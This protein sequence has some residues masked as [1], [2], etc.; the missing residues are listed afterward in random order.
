MEQYSSESAAQMD[1]VAPAQST[2]VEAELSAEAL[3]EKIRE[4]AR[5]MTSGEP[6]ADLFGVDDAFIDDV[7]GRAYQFY[8][9]K[10]FDSAET[11]L[12]GVIALDD[13]RAYP[14]LLLGDILLQKS[15]FD[16]AT[17]QF[18]RAQALNPDDGETLAKLGESMLRGGHA[19]EANRILLAAMEV[20]PDGSRHHKRSAVLQRIAQC[21]GREAQV[22]GSV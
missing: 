18:E 17:Q 14:H 15:Q 2:E 21:S 13:S 8:G 6:T 5:R 20:L 22:T 4:F 9:A 1:S 16:G 11:L 12:K 19:D 3:A 10:S 7:V